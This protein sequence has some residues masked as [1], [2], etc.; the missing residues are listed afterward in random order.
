MFV[1]M[2]LGTVAKGNNR[3]KVKPQA[4]RAGGA[5]RK[6]II[7]AIANT[8]SIVIIN[9]S[10]ITIII[11]SWTLLHL[12]LGHGSLCHRPSSQGAAPRP[13]QPHGEGALGSGGAKKIETDKLILVAFVI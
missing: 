8:K 11:S 3:G 5:L 1:R 7:V 9:I 10:I 4:L 6:A 13:G 12:F 2:F